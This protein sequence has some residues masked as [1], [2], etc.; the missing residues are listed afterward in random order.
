VHTFS[1]ACTH[2]PVARRRV[3]NMRKLEGLCE[4]CLGTL[5]RELPASDL[6]DVLRLGRAATD[7]D[8][9]GIGGAG[10]CSANHHRQTI[11]HDQ[12]DLKNLARLLGEAKAG[13]RWRRARSR[14]VRIEPTRGA[15]RGRRLPRRARTSG[16]LAD[17]CPTFF[18]KMDF[19]AK[20]IS[21]SFSPRSPCRCDGG[22]SNNHRPHQALA[23]RV[24]QAGVLRP[25]QL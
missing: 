5:Q 18:V 23:D 13:R 1:L 15:L 3:V 6:D 22:R 12:F 20:L 4:R 11:K 21:F 10:Q 17:P 25:P 2:I 19:R 8:P 16:V 24:S 14:Q 9:A 7:G